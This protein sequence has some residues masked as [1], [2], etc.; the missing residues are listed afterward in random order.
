[1]LVVLAASWVSVAH[2]EIV[3]GVEVRVRRPKALRIVGAL[4]VG[5]DMIGYGAAIEKARAQKLE[6]IVRLE[7]GSGASRVRCSACRSNC[8][9]VLVATNFIVGRCTASAIASA[10]L[11]SFFCPLLSPV[12]IAATMAL[13]MIGPMPGTVIRRKQYRWRSRSP[14][15]VKGCFCFHI[16]S[17]RNLRLTRASVQFSYVKQPKPST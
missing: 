4:D 17:S 11:K 14:D 1:M 3:P 9:A 6:I 5:A 12:P 2:I 13:E 16:R 10:S 8:W 15:R 7:I